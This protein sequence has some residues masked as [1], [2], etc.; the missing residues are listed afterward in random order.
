M[1]ITLADQIICVK[2]EIAF[3]ERVYEKRVEQ[4]VMTK[5]EADRELSRMK[6]VL[7][8]LQTLLKEKLQPRTVATI[9]D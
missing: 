5:A 8:T 9:D 7:D 2:R 6:A 3:R 4:K 1:R